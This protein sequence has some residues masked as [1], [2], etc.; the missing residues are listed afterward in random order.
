VQVRHVDYVQPESLTTALEGV[1]RLLPISG[2][3]G[4]RVAEHANVIDAAKQA[5]IELLAYTSVL[6]ADTTTMLLAADYH[7][8]EQRIKD[9]GLPYAV[10]SEGQG[11]SYSH[12][13]LQ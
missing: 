8:T 7:A 5:G 1:G 12:A 9:S 13:L 11:S 3:P 4:D 10:L 2:T 6:N